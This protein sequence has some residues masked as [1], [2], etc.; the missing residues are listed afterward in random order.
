M[1]ARLGWLG[2]RLLMWNVFLDLGMVTRI[3]RR[4]LSV[5][6]L[7]QRR[8]ILLFRFVLALIGVRLMMWLV[9]LRGH[10]MICRR[11]RLDL[12]ILVRCCRFRLILR[13]L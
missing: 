4:S 2:C 7:V 9:T 3:G 6:V 1:I 8:L 13:L 5:K 10:H 12:L 11:I